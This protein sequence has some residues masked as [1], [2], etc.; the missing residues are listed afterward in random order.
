M[1]QSIDPSD[2]YNINIVAFDTKGF[3][4]ASYRPMGRGMFAQVEGKRYWV[5][6]ADA[7]YRP[8]FRHLEPEQILL[9]SC[10]IKGMQ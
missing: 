10:V 8:E 3:V 9:R 7:C 5:V 4:R 6:I 2:L 1:E